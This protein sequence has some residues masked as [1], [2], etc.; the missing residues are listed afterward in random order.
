MPAQICGCL[1]AGRGQIL[2]NGVRP[3]AAKQCGSDCKLVGRWR[4]G[5]RTLRDDNVDHVGHAFCFFF[6][7]GVICTH[8]FGWRRCC[9]NAVGRMFVGLGSDLT[10]AY[11]DRTAWF[12]AAIVLT[13]VVSRP[14]TAQ[15][16]PGDLE[17]C[18]SHSV[19]SLR[20]FG[21][22]WGLVSSLTIRCY[23]LPLRSS[24]RHECPFVFVCDLAFKTEKMMWCTACTI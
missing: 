17:H 18:S 16:T 1:V 21:R 9:R 24:V 14:G 15:S 13:G 12:T 7:T 2:R 8:A 19:R 10:F 6:V 5:A 23:S 11:I 20:A 22:A 4:G 3:D